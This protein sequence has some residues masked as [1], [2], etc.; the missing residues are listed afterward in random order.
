[1]VCFVFASS[2]GFV[3]QLFMFYQ[4]TS[5]EPDWIQVISID[6]SKIIIS[7]IFGPVLE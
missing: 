6:S 3:M 5:R 4:Y 7:F 2:L 1:M